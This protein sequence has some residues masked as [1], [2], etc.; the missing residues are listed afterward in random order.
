MNHFF[1]NKV[2]VITGASSG[3]GEACALAFAKNECDLVLAARDENNL[4]R[5]A[6]QCRQSGVRVHTVRTDVSLENECSRLMAEVANT[7]GRIDFLINNA[8]I[9]MRA[10]FKD[11]NLDVLKQL[12]DV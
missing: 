12:M 1:K 3:I 8:G 10:L 11:V 4:N 6:E 5:V 7:F 2:A 9:S